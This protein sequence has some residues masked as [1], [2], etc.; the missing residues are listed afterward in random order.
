MKGVMGMKAWSPHVTEVEAL[1]VR[2]PA[3]LVSLGHVEAQHP[4]CA[5]LYRLAI[6]R[7]RHGHLHATQHS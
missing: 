7:G 5:H 1:I 3:P 4:P 2:P 6:N